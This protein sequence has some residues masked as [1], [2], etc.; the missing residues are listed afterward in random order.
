M[1][2]QFDK[3]GVAVQQQIW[4]SKINDLEDEMAFN[5]ASSYALS[6]AQIENV[7]KK[8]MFNELLNEPVNK[9][10]INLFC[11]EELGSK[12]QKSVGFNLLKM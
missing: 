5:L 9:Q 3:P 10:V 8:V 6:P 12:T 7:A 11:E 1:K 4:K 2:I